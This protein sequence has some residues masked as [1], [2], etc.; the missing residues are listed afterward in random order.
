ME[1]GDKSG[2]RRS[3][4]REGRSDEKEKG[5]CPQL[6]RSSDHDDG[7]GID[8]SWPVPSTCG[9]PC[10]TGWSRLV[11]ARRCADTQAD[12]AVHDAKGQSRTCDRAAA[13]ASDVAYC[14]R[15]VRR[16]W[17][18]SSGRCPGL[19]PPTCSG[20]MRRQQVSFAA[21]CPTAQCRDLSRTTTYISSSS[22][23]SSLIYSQQCA[24]TKTDVHAHKREPGQ[25]GY[26]KSICP[27]YKN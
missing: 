24:L 7:A 5:V 3:R 21:T 9:P 20:Q 26:H 10:R 12:S 18:R 14:A 22:S 2:R 6:P 11:P 27:T 23:S 13:S 4:E 17:T 19:T 15:A 25:S 8:L 16:P 1:R